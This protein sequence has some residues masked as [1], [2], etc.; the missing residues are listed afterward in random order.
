MSKEPEKTT[1]HIGD[2]ATLAEGLYNELQG[3]LENYS[4][5]I[6]GVAVIGVLE[7]LKM[8]I[9]SDALMQRIIFEEIDDDDEH[10]H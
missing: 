9:M 6:T 1:F 4:E 10:E 8:D 2:Q 7:S 3:V 5:T